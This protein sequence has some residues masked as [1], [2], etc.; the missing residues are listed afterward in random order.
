MENKNVFIAKDKTIFDD[1][2]SCMLYEW[3]CEYVVSK[4]T[5]ICQKI[6]V[7]EMLK[8]IIEKKLVWMKKLDAAWNN[9]AY[10]KENNGNI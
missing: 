2:K 7:S 1:E 5:S 3:V 10:K 9:L 8:K 6:Y 4:D